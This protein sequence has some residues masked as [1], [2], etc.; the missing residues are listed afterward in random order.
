[1][2]FYSNDA[3]FFLLNKYYSHAHDSEYPGKFRVHC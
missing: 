1:M 3:G 2:L